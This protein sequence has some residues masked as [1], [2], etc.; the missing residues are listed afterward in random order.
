MNV[1]A[2]AS[3][4]ERENE[5]HTINSTTAIRP[6]DIGCTYR[7]IRCT[8]CNQ[9]LGKTFV[10]TP[11]EMDPIRN[12]I[13]F[14]GAKL[15]SYKVGSGTALSSELKNDSSRDSDQRIDHT[16][17]LSESH[18]APVVTLVGVDAHEALHLKEQIMM[19]QAV[20]VTLN[21]RVAAIERPGPGGSKRI[22]SALT[23][24]QTKR[25]K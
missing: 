11:P 4:V 15:L 13:T 14:E 9:M 8:G 10:T 17:T 6:R 20:L 5:L 1:D 7:L 24:A 23:G 3:N 22:G 21:E 25:K 18:V 19:I 12:M 2:V 16:Q